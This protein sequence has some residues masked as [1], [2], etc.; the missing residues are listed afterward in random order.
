MSVVTTPNSP[1]SASEAPRPGPDLEREQRSAPVGAPRHH[2]VA[3]RAARAVLVSL[4]A[5]AIAFE[6]N[7]TTDPNVNSAPAAVMAIDRSH[8]SAAEMIAPTDRIAR[9][10]VASEDETFS[11]NDGV[12]SVAL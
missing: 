11:S 2:R 12:D 9:A 1:A 8:G 7:V 6:I 10:L 4:I 5:I 3:R